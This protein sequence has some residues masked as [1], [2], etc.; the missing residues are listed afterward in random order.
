MSRRVIAVALFLAGLGGGCTRDNVQKPAPKFLVRAFG[1]PDVEAEEAYADDG[2]ASSGGEGAELDHGSLDAL[3]RAHVTEEGWVDYEALAE[4]PSRL[5]DYVAA[6]GNAPFDALSRDGKLAL[7]INAYNAFT[8]RLI[9]DF[10]PVESIK[11]IPDDRR[12]DEERWVVGGRSLSLNQIE[13]RELRAKFREPRIH[14]AINCASVSCPP[15]RNEAY[16]PERIDEQLDAA[17]RATLGRSPSRWLVF[18]EREG[19]LRLSQ[20]F[21]WFEADFEESEGSVPAYVARYHPRLRRYL[22]D[23]KMDGVDVGHLPYDW[24]LNRIGAQVD[25]P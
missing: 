18:D 14:F 3:L 19:R 24:H 12:W 10:H 20:I 6:L 7:L 1:P 23:P 9:L 13:N 11:D 2:V 25:V 17:A 8:L 15:L 5:D 22:D 21:L 16:V 4:D